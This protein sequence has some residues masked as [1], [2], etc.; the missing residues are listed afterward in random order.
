[1]TDR[2]GR[3]TPRYAAHG[4][5]PAILDYCRLQ[6]LELWTYPSAEAQ[7]AALS[8]D[9]AYDAHDIDDGLRAELFALDELAKLPLLGDLLREID[10]GHP[11]L[12]PP[13]RVHE[14]IRRLITRMIEDVIAESRRRLT[15]AGA[16]SVDAVRRAGAPVIAFSAEVEKTD[17]QIKAFLLPRVY[18]EK[19]VMRI[20]GEAEAVV[21]DLFDAYWREPK[22]LPPEWRQGFER[23]DTVTQACRI[24]DFIAG[25]TDRYALIEHARLFDTTPEL[26]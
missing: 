19:R 10:K 7:V 13:R 6:D 14:L 26:R 22:E 16:Q 9:I 23:C 15:M 5:P 3:P 18:R 12:E 1:M 11:R 21:A 4:V 25:M 17:R 24:A 2:S 20:M 8:D